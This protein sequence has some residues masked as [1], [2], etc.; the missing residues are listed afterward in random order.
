M[1]TPL[2]RISLTIEGMKHTVQA[3]LGEYQAQIAN[4]IQMAVERA[5]QPGNIQQVI[6][7]TAAREINEVI[8]DE[9]RRYYRYGDGRHVVRA[10]LERRLHEL[11]ELD[12]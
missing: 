2:P 1:S 6:N 8:K 11:Q 4:E 10:A 3:A 12:R 9:L 7:D 5:C